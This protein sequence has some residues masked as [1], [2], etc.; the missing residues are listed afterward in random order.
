MT[1]FMGPAAASQRNIAVWRIQS[2]ADGQL[3]LSSKAK[4]FVDGSACEFG[5]RANDHL[6]NGVCVW[7]GGGGGGRGEG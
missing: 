4:G 3:A 7:G 5:D 2:A 6:C 1:F